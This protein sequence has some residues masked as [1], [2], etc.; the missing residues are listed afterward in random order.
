MKMKKDSLNFKLIN[1][2]I[3][4]LM[5]YLLYQTGNLWTGMIGK[6]Y[7]IIFPFLIAFIVAY[8]LHP[9]LRYL[10]SKKIPKPLSIFI[11]IAII[12]GI[13][14]I[15]LI[16]VAPLLFSQLSNLFNSIIAFIKQISVDYDLNFGGLQES[17]SKSFNEIIV[18]LGKY[19]SDGAINFIGVSLNYISTLVIAFSA[20]I[21]FLID[22]DKIRAMIKKYLIKHNQ[23]SYFYLKRLDIEMKNYLTGFMK[24]VLITIFEYSIAFLIIGHPDALL[25][26]CL[27]AIASLIPYFGGIITNIIAAITAFVIS[28]ALFIRTVIAFFI[29]SNLDGYVINPIV[30]GKTN[31]VH[32]LIVILSVFAGGI[33]FGILGVIISL[34]TAI[35]ILT[36]YKFYK[37][38]IYDKIDEVKE[39]SK[40]KEAEEHK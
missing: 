27:A 32:P 38:D 12:I 3:L 35:L 39:K 26:G 17:L 25:L 36:T 15:L 24:I 9:L 6:I 7:Q 23:K 1:T 19:V 20:A 14:A 21:Y 34:P 10:Q 37:T 2:T 11:I 13:V 5:I 16:L 29:L 8:A 28:P 40:L 22:M 33:L 31:Q 30:Y 4:V 18:S